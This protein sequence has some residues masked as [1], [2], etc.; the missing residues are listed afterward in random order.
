MIYVLIYLLIGSLLTLLCE[1]FMLELVNK[2]AADHNYNARKTKWFRRAVY[3]SAVI[4]WPLMFIP[5]P[6]N[7]KGDDHDVR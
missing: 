7:K 2:Y 5:A 1:R 4:A 3:M 6:K